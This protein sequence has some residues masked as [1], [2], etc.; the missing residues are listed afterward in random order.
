MLLRH[1]LHRMK[2]AGCALFFLLSLSL[3]AQPSQPGA[4][5]PLTNTR[6]VP[7]TAKWTI[8]DN[9]Q[10]RLLFWSA[11]H[12]LRVTPLALGERRLGRPVVSENSL[13]AVVRTGDGFLVVGERG[14]KLIGRLLDRN[15][16]PLGEAFDIA[17]NGRDPHLAANGSR[18]L[19]VYS[20][21][22]SS[23][24]TTR[25]IPL[26][27]DG[28]PAGASTPVSV[29]AGAF[30]AMIP[31]GAGFVA[32]SQGAGDL[33]RTDFDG[34]GAIT[35]QEPL[36]ATAQAWQP[37]LFANGAGYVATWRTSDS[38]AIETRD[39]DGR[40]VQRTLLGGARLSIVRHDSRLLAFWIT[41]E[42]RLNAC[43]IR[44]DG[45]I[46]APFVIAET[47]GDEHIT[48]YTME[49]DDLVYTTSKN[50]TRTIHLLRFDAQARTATEIRVQS[51]EGDAISS[52]ELVRDRSRK[53]F[54]AD[55]GKAVTVRNLSDASG[56]ANPLFYA[57][58]TQSIVDAVSTPDA[59]LFLWTE[60]TTT[61]YAG[62]RD[63]SGEW[64]EHALS[65]I[66]SWAAA[67]TDGHDFLVIAWNAW[68]QQW[69]ALRLDGRGRVLSRGP[70]LYSGTLPV[71]VWNGTNYVVLTE[72][73]LGPSVRPISPAGVIGDPV[74]LTLTSPELARGFTLASDGQGGV[75]VVWQKTAIAQTF[76][77]ESVYATRLGPNLQQ[78][79]APIL[80]DSDAFAPA[81]AWN[82]ANYVVTWGRAYPYSGARWQK[83]AS[84]GTAAGAIK[85]FGTTPDREQLAFELARAG[86]DVAVSWHDATRHHLAYLGHD[87]IAV[88]STSAGYPQIT[89][90]PD[91][92]VAFV[93]E[94]FVED[95]PQHG[96]DRVRMR[97]LDFAAPSA[98]PDAPR[99]SASWQSGRVHVQWTAPPQSVNG[100]RL[101]Y[102]VDRGT[103]NELER[104]FDR[105]E[106]ATTITLPR[107]TT[108]EFRVG[109][110][111]D[112][113]TSAYSEPAFLSL[114]R[115]AVN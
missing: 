69:H 68:T 6:Y 83:L 33:I 67:A 85:N 49:G 84:D 43:F 45:L 3:L 79:G 64:S 96:A 27:P 71:V 92:R 114:K 95:A 82:G 99:L 100:Y 74:P 7:Q 78:S 1:K 77:I 10:R 34:A 16:M 23:S 31:H 12:E 25:A 46:E 65:D 105:D 48:S 54:L 60:Q 4:P 17:P 109:A 89:A 66:D 40:F 5:V 21:W 13:G 107:G 108:F 39:Q 88:D 62:I 2:V 73:D 35:R 52:S 106:H 93:D 29:S 104:W 94:A 61:L 18:I 59:T 81:A 75:L 42:Q 101:E 91:G 22:T 111:S 19:L 57:S 115:R 63:R 56:E 55:D 72:D 113:G 51:E 32:L 30:A 38:V 36:G 9:G 41:N 44:A 97:I 24:S 80:L 58:A 98:V 15:A 20:E 87:E 112:V 50:G 90:L 76:A 11:A 14:T 70:M 26:G 28:R 102:R 86:D 37:A 8:V 110:W 53:L 103:W 47:S